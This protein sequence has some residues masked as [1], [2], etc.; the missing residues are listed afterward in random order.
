MQSTHPSASRVEVIGDFNGWNGDQYG[1]NVRWDQS[2][3]WEG[4][5]PGIDSGCLYKYR[6]FSNLDDKVREKADPFARRYECPPKTAS[7]VWQDDYQ[8]NDQQWLQQR[9]Q[10]NSL[11]SPISIYE[12][13]IGSWKKQLD[14]V[15]SL[16]Y[17]QL[18]DE[19]VDY[20]TEMNFTHVEFLPV[21]EHPY[22]PSWGY[23]CTGYFAPSSRYGEPHEFKYLV[24]ALHHAGIGVYLDWVPAHFPTDEFALADFDGSA[25]FEHPDSSKG[26][27]PDWN[28]AI[29]NFERPQVVSF[30][31][32]S[33]HFW[34]DQ[35]HADGLR[36]DAVASMIYLDYSRQQGQWTPNQ[37]GGNEY[38]AAID[39][40]KKLNS[41]IYQAF[42]DIQMIAEESTAFPG[43][44]T[45]VDHG[46]LG[47]GMKWMMGW[48]NDTLSYFQRDAIHRR[49]H[50]DELTNSI[51]YVFSENF[52]LPLSHDEVVHGKNALLKKMPG[53]EWQQFANLRLLYVY[54]F[55][56]PGQK[57]LFMGDEF[58]QAQEWSV[59]D[60]L[61]WNCL[62]KPSHEDK[63]PH[64]GLQTLVSSLNALYR[65]Q[66]ALYANNFDMSSWQWIDGG[67]STNSVLSYLRIAGNSQLLVILNGTPSPH[68]LYRVGVPF[69][70][71]YEV[72]IN[73]DSSQF[74]GSQ[75]HVE[76]YYNA[77]TIAYHGQPYSI[78][79]CLP[80]L[81]GLI[82]QP[83][84]L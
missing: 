58:G 75:F 68:Q 76:A 29:F 32:S 53:D 8:W 2:G 50:H 56:H 47:F 43:V 73:S 54:M 65:Q 28:S 79:V 9:H 39:M 42:P 63:Q 23:L 69:N 70:T 14:N 20:I 19:L 55:T 74:A 66:P 12:L 15:H 36:V 5:I 11:N 30:L 49:Y 84:D 27:H 26:F 64:Q 44:T 4:F 59:N 31:L 51:H 71:R 41:S 1:L 72:L 82:L 21:M 34:C 60:S 78:E 13:H 3:I 67:D 7:M 16:S 10:S 6:I 45:P 48:M 57:L 25:L 40:L 17:R 33:A 46:G 77:Q 61:D 24:D 35:Y 18:A 22:Y 62:D 38:L 37:F 52:L 81:A 83:L 80:P